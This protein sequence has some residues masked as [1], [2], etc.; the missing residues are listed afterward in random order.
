MKTLRLIA[1]LFVVALFFQ[2]CGDKT[3]PETYFKDKSALSA[4][5]LKIAPYVIPYPEDVQAAQWYAQDSASVV[6]QNGYLADNLATLDRYFIDAKD[7]M[8]FYL[9]S[10]RDRS[11]LYEHYKLYGG[12]YALKDDGK[13]DSLVEIFISP[14][15]TKKELEPKGKALFEAMTAKRTIDQYYGN[16]EYVEWPYKG[17]I[18][19]VKEKKWVMT[20]ENEMYFLKEL[21][22]S[23]QEDLYRRSDS[24]RLLK[25]SKKKNS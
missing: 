23:V 2:S 18:Y 15:L 8:R 24:M 10:I 13:I 17:L 4:E 22:D 16:K 19:D 14:R 12:M 20:P 7:S 1:A 5:L 6:R 21:K 11:S 25:E 3:K 9:V